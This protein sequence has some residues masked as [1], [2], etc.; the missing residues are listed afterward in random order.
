LT[1]VLALGGCA[2]APVFSERAGESWRPFSAGAA[3]LRAAGANV[4]TMVVSGR[5]GTG[6][7]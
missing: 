1:G 2:V 4:R 3:R 6:H 7:S 5:S